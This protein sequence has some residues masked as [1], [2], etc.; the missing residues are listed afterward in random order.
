MVLFPLG[1]M[2][3]PEVR[4]IAEEAKVGIRSIRRDGMDTVKDEQKRSE[5]TEDQK[6]DFEEKIQ[7]LTDKYVAEIDKLLENKEKEIMSI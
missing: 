5:I 3:K 7:K 2:E 4:K 1:K 6:A